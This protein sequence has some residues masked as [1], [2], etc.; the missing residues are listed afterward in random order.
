MPD[1]DPTVLVLLPERL[2]RTLRLGPFPSARD[3]LK[4][5]AWTAVG[6]FLV[7][8]LGPAM[9]V[10][11]GLAGLAVAIVRVDGRS[12][13]G[14]ALRFLRWQIRRFGGRDLVTPPGAVR[15]DG[16]SVA[17]DTDSLVAVVRTA[18]V[19]LAYLPP[20]DLSR[21]FELYRDLLRALDGPAALHIA[22][23]PIH[24]APYVP[25][26]PAPAGAE[27]LARA[28]Y[29]ELVGVIVRRRSLRQVWLAI[30]QPGT[31]ARSLSALEVRTSDLIER[32]RA[33]GLRP[34]RLRGHGIGEAL[35]RMGIRTGVRR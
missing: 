12:P 5:L 35:H 10:P 30:G 29:R 8:A 19:P 3:A 23:T 17:R 1:S 22:R 33:L 31:D 28:G 2:D 32:L 9:V 4:F 26:E 16:R 20:T 7:P 25:A 24:P 18:G 27:G 15:G 11:F 14:W 6:A 34:A 21:R 13:D